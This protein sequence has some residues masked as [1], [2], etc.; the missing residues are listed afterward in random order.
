[1]YFAFTFWI[2]LVLYKY[3]CAFSWYIEKE[4]F[5]LCTHVKPSLGGGERDHN[6]IQFINSKGKVSPAHTMKAYSGNWSITVLFLNVDTDIGEWSA[7][8]PRCYTKGER[9]LGTWWLGEDIPTGI[10]TPDCSACSLVTI[11]R[12]L[13][14]HLFHELWEA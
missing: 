3:I 10:H 7:S 5:M 12:M 1:M 8:C 2:T 9:G 11:V 6:I 14:W 13:S 4:V